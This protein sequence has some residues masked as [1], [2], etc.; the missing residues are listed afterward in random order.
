[1]IENKIYIIEWSDTFSHI[2]WLNKK[3]IEKFTKDISG[4][5][6]TVGYYIGTFDDFIVIASSLNTNPDM[7]DYG[8]I[9]Y[10]PRGTIKNINKATR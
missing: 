2:R 6:K 9:T 4:Y 8:T 5:I 3:E 10:I 7:N 1:M